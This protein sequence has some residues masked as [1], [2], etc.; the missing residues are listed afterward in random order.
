[1]KKITKWLGR[2]F[3]AII[4]LLCALLGYAILT[5]LSTERPVGFQITQTTDANG[6]AFPIA[7]WYPTQARPWPTVFAGTGLMNVAQDG[8]ISGRDLPLVL[9]SHGNGGGAL[10]HVDLALALANAG[11][12][13]AA[14][15]HTGDN[16]TDQ[17]KLGSVSLFSGRAKEL[18]ASIEHLLKQWQGHERINPERIGAYGFSA[19]GTTVLTLV[20]AQPDLRL[21]AQHCANASEFVCD[22]LRQSKSPLV[23]MNAATMG[24]AFS[25]DSRIKAAVLAAPGLGFTMLP[26]GLANVSVPIQLWSGDQDDKVPYA[27]NAKLVRAALGSRAEFHSVDGAGHF[28]F[29]APCGLLKPPAFCADPGQFDRKAFHLKMNAGVVAFFDKHLKKP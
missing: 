25:A 9:I 24:E 23:D 12:I 28:A 20:G 18:H 11:Y 22:V 29:L 1:M 14:P 17:S 16:Y 2:G 4:V 3:I 10:S 6:R 13:V 8:A 26:A 15:M 7:L 5:A 21:V 27:T 19:G